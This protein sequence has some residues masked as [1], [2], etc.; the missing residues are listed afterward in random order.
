MIL[1]ISKRS[2]EREAL[3]ETEKPLKLNYQKRVGNDKTP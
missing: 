2:D 1:N 3:S